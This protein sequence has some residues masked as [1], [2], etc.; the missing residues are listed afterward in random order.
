VPCGRPRFERY[1]GTGRPDGV[2]CGLRAIL[3]IAERESQGERHIR[4]LAPLAPPAFYAGS[5]I[6]IT[7]L[8]WGPFRDERTVARGRDPV[9]VGA[10]MTVREPLDRTL[11]LMRDEI[12]ETVTDDELIWASGQ[13]MRCLARVYGMSRLIE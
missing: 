6:G 10:H 4:L 7:L 3:H 12:R 2:R 1:R 8:G 9:A 13:K 11:L 5:A